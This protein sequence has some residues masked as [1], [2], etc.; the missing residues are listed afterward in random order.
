M[1]V[2]EEDVRARSRLVS[3]SRRSRGRR[4]GCRLPSDY[5]TAAQLRKMNGPVITV[6]HGIAADNLAGGD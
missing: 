5:L 6:R 3:A 1:T 4:S 2:Y